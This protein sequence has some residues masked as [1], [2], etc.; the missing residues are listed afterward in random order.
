MAGGWVLQLQSD[1]KAIVAGEI[2]NSQQDWLVARFNT[3][4]SLDISFGSVGWT[5]FRRRRAGPRI[6]LRRCAIDRQ[7]RCERVLR[8]STILERGPGPI[9]RGGP[10]QRQRGLRPDHP[11]QRDGLHPHQFSGLKNSFAALAVQPDDKFV[12]V[13]TVANVRRL[14]AGVARYTAAG[15]LDPSFNVAVIPCSPAGIASHGP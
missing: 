7:D 4:G 3:N 15:V 5:G 6:R 12:R 14:F 8:L 2:V 13:R 9:H 10:R 11:R 1:G